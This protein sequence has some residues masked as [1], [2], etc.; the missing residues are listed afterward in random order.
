MH[1]DLQGLWNEFKARNSLVGNEVFLTSTW[2]DPATQAAEYAKGRD[3]N[4]NVIDQSAVVT[5]AAPGSS[6]HECT[7]NDDGVTPGA[8]AFDFAIQL[9]DEGNMLDWDSDDEQWTHA[10]EIGTQMG[11]VNGK[12]FKN[13]QGE[14]LGDADHFELPAWRTYVAGTLQARPV[15]QS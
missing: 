5:N 13:A 2:R 14:P 12:N 8:R 15:P 9:G 1:P 10:I 6:P 3:A 7:M 11:L 4:G